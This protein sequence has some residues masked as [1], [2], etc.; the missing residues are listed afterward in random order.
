[1]SRC[2]GLRAEK[3]CSY[4]DGCVLRI[5]EQADPLWSLSEGHV[6]DRLGHMACNTGLQWGT[7][8]SVVC[9]V[10]GRDPLPTVTNNM[11]RIRPHCKPVAVNTRGKQLGER[12]PGMP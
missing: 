9:K 12:S 2:A 6:R 11:R 3:G 10:G 5:G 1:M 8:I 7:V 4:W